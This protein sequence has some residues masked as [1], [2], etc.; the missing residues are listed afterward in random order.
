MS[1]RLKN[2]LLKMRE[3]LLKEIDEGIKI[4]R[5]VAGRDVGDFYDDVD[6]EK[7]KQMYHM[8][9]ERERE[10][11]KGIDAALN[12]IEDKI[13]G[14]CEECDEKINKERLKILPFTKYCVNCQA[15][16]EKREKHLA[17]SG[18]DTVVYK[19]VSINDIGITDE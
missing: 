12:K 3:E 18:E 4:Q 17:Q 2:S 19:D 11:I 6:I 15:E 1:K 9:G 5:D 14:R 10:K 8:L 7:D 13:Y 16:I